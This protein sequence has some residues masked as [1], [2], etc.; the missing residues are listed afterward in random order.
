MK[1]SQITSSSRSSSAAARVAALCSCLLLVS[2][3]LSAQEHRTS[4]SHHCPAIAASQLDAPQLEAPAKLSVALKTHIPCVAGDAGGYPCQDIDLMSFMPLSTIGGGD[5][6]DLWGWTDPLTGKEYALMGRSNGTAFVDITDPEAPIYLGNLPTASTNSAWRDIKV[7]ADH[8]LIVSEA[9]GHGMQVFHL[10]DLRDV[11]SPPVTFSATGHH[12]GFSNAHN[13]VVNEDTGFGYAVGTNQCGGG[14]YM[15]DLAKPDDPIFVGCFADDGYTH[16]AQCVLYH[17]PDTD[18]T[19]REI[20]I[21]SNE[22]TLTFVDVTDKANPAQIARIGYSGS[23]YTHQGWLTDD[24]TRFLLDDEGDENNFGHNTKTYIWDVG[25][26]DNPVLINTYLG[27]EDSVD[28]N[29]YVRGGFLYQAN[30]DSGLRILSLD[31]VLNGEISE[32]AYFDIVPSGGSL[33]AWSVYPWFESGNVIVSGI[34]EGLFVLR[35]ALCQEPAVPTGLNAVA[36]GDH[37]ISLTWDAGGAGT[38]VDIYRAFGACE[39]GNP[40]E[41]V[42]SGVTGTQFDDTVSGQV[43]YAYELRRVDESGACRSEVSA[44]ASATTS[45]ACTAPP[46]F[47]GVGGVDPLGLEDCALRLSWD[48]GQANCG[49]GVSYK[50]YRDF[51]S[52]FVPGEENLMETVGT[53]TWTDST[54]Y[55]GQLHYYVV[56]ATDTG[57]GA[58]DGNQ[59]LGAGLPTGPPADGPWLN[60]AELADAGMIFTTVFGAFGA[61]E[62]PEHIGWETSDARANTGDRSYFSTYGNN[63]CIAVGTPPIALTV[64]EASQLSFWTFYNTQNRFDGGV[65]QISVDGGPWTRLNIDGGYP[66]TFVTA[67]NACGFFAGDPAFSGTSGDW[68]EVT[69]DLSAWA[70][71]SI[72]LRWLFSTDGSATLE[73][74]YL[75]DVEITH[76]QAPGS[77]LGFEL[78][79]D[80]FEAGNTA[81]WSSVVSGN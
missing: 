8:A 41:L 16:D 37:T 24:H 48:A 9:G 12:D 56:R 44:C 50:I 22:D 75:D 70:G 40:R 55:D 34:G 49:P 2:A 47:S 32:V 77:C 5:G 38:T 20:C 59:V 61:I 17:G 63:S 52:D 15:M 1:N 73:G 18:Y 72:E 6:N 33:G 19:G 81:A 74:W 31:E 53:L 57:N 54:V 64:G 71:S 28:H 80:G 7:Y 66:S 27:S 3:N 35:P 76:A 79:D 62:A 10:E 4:V 42:A 68:T 67:D 13:L 45:G 78:F 60:G 58:E 51:Q 23:G 11:V 43:G 36:A 25:N 30:Y 39:D 14:L 21:N 69:A 29:Q 26:L 46:I 65:V